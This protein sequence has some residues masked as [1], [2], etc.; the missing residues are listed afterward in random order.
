[1]P[2]K[3]QPPINMAVPAP[4]PAPDT[5]LTSEQV[6]HWAHLVANGVVSFPSHFTPA[7]ARAL[8]CQ[9]RRRRRERLIG[10]IARAIA[11]EIWRSRQ[12]RTEDDD[13]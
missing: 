4:T 1:M 11:T 10:F 2:R 9:V 3:T 5:T 8:G 12:H 6:D 13:A 7:D